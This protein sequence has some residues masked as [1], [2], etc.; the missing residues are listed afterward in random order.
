VVDVPSIVNA[1]ATSL[2]GSARWQGPSEGG[3]LDARIQ[4]AKRLTLPLALFPSEPSLPTA[5]PL[6]PPCA[7]RTVA[8][9]LRL[10]IVFAHG[11][12]AHHRARLLTMQRCLMPMALARGAV[13]HATL[14]VASMATNEY[15][16]SKVFNEY[17]THNFSALMTDVER[18]SYLLAIRR[19]KAKHHSAWADRLVQWTVD[20]GADAESMA[21]VGFKSLEA[22]IWQ[23]IIRDFRAGR[24]V[25]NRCPACSRI[26]KTPLARQCLWCG[27][28]WH[29]R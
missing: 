13:W 4:K 1:I 20:A 11:D 22:T 8:P 19:E 17:V 5:P 23:R 26:V 27:H 7:K 28:D 3:T 24:L 2:P 16:D 21:K 9:W 15:D 12:L 6:K 18:R 25:I 14:S 10:P 29:E